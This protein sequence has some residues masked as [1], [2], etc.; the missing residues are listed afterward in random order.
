[1]DKLKAINPNA[2]G[3]VGVA[4]AVL[5]PFLPE[6]LDAGWAVAAVTLAGMLAQYA[7]RFARWKNWLP[8]ALVMLVALGAASPAQA[9]DL[10]RI[11]VTSKATFAEHEQFDANGESLGF[12]QVTT[13]TTAETYFAPMVTVSMLRVNLKR[14]ADYR[15]G[16]VPGVGYGFHWSPGWYDSKGDDPFLS[17]GVFLEGGLQLAGDDADYAVFTV[18]PAVTLLKWFSVGL[19]YERRIALTEGVDDDGA[20]VLALGIA[21]AF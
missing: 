17:V 14:R 6:K 18:L 8:P 7:V 9:E 1:M 16:V 21:S 19:G 13:G 20:A 15:A 4:A 10:A 2:Q 5:I 3:W 11:T 12:A